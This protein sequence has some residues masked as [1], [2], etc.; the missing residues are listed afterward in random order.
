MRWRIL[1]AAALSLAPLPAAADVTARYQVDR[2]ALTIEVDDNGD[3]RAEIA[4]KFM[5]LRRG[6]MEYVVLF[7]GATPLVIERQAFFDL[8]GTKLRGELAKSTEAR[9]DLVLT[10]SGEEEIAG[11]RGTLWTVAL[12]KPGGN[13]IEAVIAPD[14]DLA[15]VSTVFAGMLDGGLKAF[16]GLIPESNL[17]EL[18]REVFAKGAPLRVAMM[19]D[20]RL[21]SVSKAPI[22]SARF[23]LPGPVVDAAAFDRALSGSD[24]KTEVVVPPPP[25]SPQP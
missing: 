14:M 2:D 3:Y 24:A 10:K 19:V 23:A 15:P 1:A 22:D 25:P 12:D 17:P 11:R 6:G 21:G 4:G 7:Q 16:G 18:L 5:L 9:R 13:R 20:L 8:V